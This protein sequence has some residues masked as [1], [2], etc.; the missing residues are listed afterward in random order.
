MD[1]VAPGVFIMK[2]AEWGANTKYPRRGHV[3]PITQWKHTT[4]HHTV[5]IDND[6]TPDVWET[7]AKVKKQ[8]RRLQTLRP[9][10]GN[11]IPYS[12]V[13]FLMSNGTIIVCEG[14]GF[15]RTGAHTIGHNSDSL[16]V[17]WEG[18]FE[19]YPVDL[20]PYIQ[21][22]NHFLG[23][24]KFV[25]GAKFL[26]NRPHGIPT[27][28]TIYYHQMFSATACCGRVIIG[29][30]N[31]FIYIE[32]KE[33]EGDTLSSKEYDELSKRID[34]TNKVV[35]TVNKAQQEDIVSNTEKIDFHSKQIT[36]M[37]NAIN[38]NKALIKTITSAVVGLK[39]FAVK[40]VTMHNTSGG[41]TDSQAVPIVEKV[42]KTLRDG[43]VEDE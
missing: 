4:F 21:K 14:R 8:M 41:A 26:T 3:V 23:W 22:V 29:T 9:D 35:K 28:Q 43:G 19:N 24:M 34:G 15:K 39:D 36:I 5:S 33:P 38:A 2:R 13:I 11:D 32:Y 6:A 7:I 27:A 20:K 25:A 18:D 10:L 12:W 16:G 30:I 40:H 1:E 31:S 17:A 37:I 42:T